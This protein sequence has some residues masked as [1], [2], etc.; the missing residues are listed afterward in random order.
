VSTS[1]CNADKVFVPVLAVFERVVQGSQSANSVSESL[2]VVQP[3]KIESQVLLRPS[4]KKTTNNKQ[5]NNKQ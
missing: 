4:G 3:T 1:S 2:V 5:A